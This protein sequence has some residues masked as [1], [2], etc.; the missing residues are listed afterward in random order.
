MNILEINNLSLSIW[1]KE[2]LK[3]VSFIVPDGKITCIVGESGS[4]KSM[5]V[6]SVLG[7]MP[8]GSKRGVNTDIKFYGDSIFSIF[9]DPMNSF[10]QSVKIYKIGRAHV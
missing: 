2:I 1:N 6:R 9:Q 4:G 5:T 10:N 3:D 8:R 7:L